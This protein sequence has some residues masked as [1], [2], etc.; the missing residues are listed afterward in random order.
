MSYFRWSAGFLCSG[1]AFGAMTAAAAADDL[2][3][4]KAQ[5]EVLQSKVSK[6]ETAP[7]PQVRPGERR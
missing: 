6:L 2:S 3:A 7:A 5:L 4:L 1:V